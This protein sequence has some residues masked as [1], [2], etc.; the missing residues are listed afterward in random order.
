V[1]AEPA[2]NKAMQTQA[3]PIGKENRVISMLL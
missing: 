3:I 2:T 1:L